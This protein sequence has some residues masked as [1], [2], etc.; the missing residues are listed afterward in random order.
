MLTVAEVVAIVVS[1]I[2]PSVVTPGNVIAL[3]ALSVVGT[4]AVATAAALIIA[5]S[6]Q[7]VSAGLTPTDA[8]LSSATK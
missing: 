2:G 4:I 7:W 5:P 1:L 8:Q 6:L 3:V